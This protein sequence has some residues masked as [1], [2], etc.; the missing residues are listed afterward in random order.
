MRVGSGPNLHDGR[1]RAMIAAIHDPKVLS[2]KL[3]VG[4]KVPFSQGYALKAI[5][6][7]IGGKIVNAGQVVSGFEGE[8][9]LL[10]VESSKGGPVAKSL[11]LDDGCGVSCKYLNLG[12]GWK[13]KLDGEWVEVP[14][15]SVEVD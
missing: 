5:V 13:A 7:S 14:E 2:V 12:D 11:W 8:G 4:P 15:F 6:A 10:Y 1:A 3:F 9:C